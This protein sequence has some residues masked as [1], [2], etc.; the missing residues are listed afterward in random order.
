MSRCLLLLFSCFFFF[1]FFFF[2][3]TATTE[4]YTLSLHDALPIAWASGL[5]S[6]HGLPQRPFRDLLGQAPSGNALSAA[7]DGAVLKPNLFVSTSAASLALPSL[8]VCCSVPHLPQAEFTMAPLREPAQPSY[9]LRRDL[10]VPERRLTPRPWKTLRSRATSAPEASLKLDAIE[11]GYAVPLTRLN[12][13][14]WCIDLSIRPRRSAPRAREVA[15]QDQSIER[16]RVKEPT[17]TLLWAREAASRANLLLS[18]REASPRTQVCLTIGC[19]P[20]C[21]I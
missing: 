9:P 13:H 20:W 11:S 2:N 14:V 17:D 16:E 15:E 4:I 12:L 6:L 10:P 21:E 18:A 3:D 5:P 19:Y 1:L 8:A 7:A